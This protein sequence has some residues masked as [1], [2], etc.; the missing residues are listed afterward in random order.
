M[1]GI[2]DKKYA[3]IL[4]NTSGKV[5]SFLFSR[6]I[7]DV[8][9]ETKGM[10]QDDFMQTF[11]NAYAIPLLEPDQRDLKVNALGISR[12]IGFQIVY[13]YRS[14]VGFELNFFDEPRIID[15]ELANQARVI[16]MTDYNEAGSMLLRA[17]DTAKVV[18]SK[19]N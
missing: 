5:T 7:L 11:S 1:T 3:E 17:I 4:A 12:T 6:E 14:P 19:F 13:S 8:L 15:E 18:E 10:S 16:G 2:P 9:F